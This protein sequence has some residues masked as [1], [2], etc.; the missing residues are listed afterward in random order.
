M[1]YIAEEWLR[2]VEAEYQ[3]AAF[4]QHFTLWLIQAGASPDL[5]RDGLRIVDDEIVHAEMSYQTFL[6]A[7]GKGVPKLDRDALGL[8]RES[9]ILEDD[10]LRVALSIF[11]LGET[12]AVPLFKRMREQCAEV[13]ARTALDRILVDEVRHRDFGWTVLDYLLE[14]QPNL[15]HL[16]NLKRHVPTLLQGLLESYGANSIT[17]SCSIQERSWG[18]IPGTEYREILVRCF[19]R[20]YRPRFA[21]VGFDIS[22]VLSELPTS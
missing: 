12:V 2:R 10:L 4:T 1:Q 9:D 5:I 22:E 20:D 3:S 11:C 14:T 7:G 13:S 21:R 15:N 6:A 19:Q 18:L 8:E 16:A 17:A